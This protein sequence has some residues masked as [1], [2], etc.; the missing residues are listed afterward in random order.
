MKTKLT[1]QNSTLL[2]LSL[3][4]GIGPATVERLVAG[5]SLD[6]LSV[7]YQF[8]EIDFMQ[9]CGISQRLAHLL[10]S[11]LADKRRLDFECELMQLHDIDF[12]TI[13]DAE[14]PN[15][16]KQI[17]MPPVV[18]YVQGKLPAAQTKNLA[19]VG[20]R[21]ANAYA[22]RV[23][24]L[25]LPPLVNHTI[26][27][28]SGGALGAD[29]IAH[30]VALENN[31]VTVAVLGAGLLRTYPRQNNALF[32]SIVEHGGALVSPFPLETEAMPGNFPARNRIIAGLSQVCLVVQAAEKSGAL[33]TASWSLDAGRDVCAVPGAIDDPLSAG[34]NNLLRQGAHV[35]TGP[36]DLLHLF[37]VSPVS[38][39]A[40]QQSLVPQAAHT[41]DDELEA[42]IYQR[43]EQPIGFDDLLA[44][45]QIDHCELQEKL[46]KL[47]LDG[48][49]EQNFMG[50]WKAIP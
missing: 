22:Y 31:G 44:H 40:Q 45:L 10:V 3:I 2:H 36:H 24:R 19:V 11:G 6:D 27:I 13:A 25:L 46:F 18:L 9:R 50:L 39:R 20:S 21:K 42:N 49:L 28:V 43:C 33:I 8:S 14:Y 1:E 23:T 26:C 32:K 4:S 37:G 34:C 5:L 35:I 16:L 15:L 47:Q 48:K 7:L 41:F 17:H 29:A 12:V 38:D 30:S